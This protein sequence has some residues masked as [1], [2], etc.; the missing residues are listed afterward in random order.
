[1]SEEKKQ[2]LHVAIIMDGNGRWA[3]NKKLPRAMGHRAGV[4]RVRDIVKACP[5]RG[6]T[7]LT[8]YAFST[9]NWKR[10]KDEVGL[11]MT[12][13]LKYIKGEVKELNKQGV[14]LRIVGDLSP[15]SEP[16]R[17]AANEAYEKTK[18]NTRLNLNVAVNY[19]SRAEILRAA[20]ILAQKSADGKLDQSEIDEEFFS[21]LMYVGDPD[22]II[23]TSG[24]QRLSNFML[25]QCAYSEFYFTD[26]HWPDF[27]EKQLDLALESYSKRGRRFGGL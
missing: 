13:L 22:L 25:W 1:M 18:H 5:D 15:L 20:K 17:A 8:L 14:C 4:E 23:R 9:E 10:P 11:L 12:L 24:E 27:D 2:S 21:S 19:G 3:K 6:V 16:L 7:S 26:L